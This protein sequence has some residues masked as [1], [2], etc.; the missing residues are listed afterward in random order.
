MG[1]QSA[2]I[3]AACPGSGMLAAEAPRGRWYAI[4]KRGTCRRCNR[5]FALTWDGYVRKHRVTSPGLPTEAR[6]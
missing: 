6:P 2:E 1:E 5:E 3:G 4:P